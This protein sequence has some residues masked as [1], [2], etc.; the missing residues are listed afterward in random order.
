M[1]TCE[2]FSEITWRE[3]LKNPTGS[4][5]TKCLGDFAAKSVS[6]AIMTGAFGLKVPQILNIVSTG[7]VEG[8]SPIAFYSEVPAAMTTVLYNYSIKSPLTNYGETIIILAQNIILVILLWI[9][10]KPRPSLLEI[11]GV[12]TIFFAI[13]LGSLYIPEGARDI[14]YTI[15]SNGLLISSRVPQILKN[16]RQSSTGQL[17]SLTTF[18]LFAGTIARILTTLKDNGLNFALLSVLFLS[19]LLSTTLLV[20]MWIYSSKQGTKKH[21]EL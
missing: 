18:L 10:M 2:I 4:F 12:S 11:I 15:S 6:Y 9:H 13:L 7:S 1:M 21:K 17:S 19:L 20:Q 3:I 8:L 5:A 14:C 16:F